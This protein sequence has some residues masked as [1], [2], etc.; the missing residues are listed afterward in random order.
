M[1]DSEVHNRQWE[2]SEKERRFSGPMAACPLSLGTACARTQASAPACAPL[3]VLGPSPRA[4]LATPT[5]PA[6]SLRI[7]SAL[8][9]PESRGAVGPSR[10]SLGSFSRAVEEKVRLWSSPVSQWVSFFS[11]LGIARCDPDSAQSLDGEKR[12]TWPAS[13]IRPFKDSR[14]GR[15][16][17]EIHIQSKSESQRHTGSIL[18]CVA[19]KFSRV[20]AAK[21]SVSDWTQTSHGP[22]TFFWQKKRKQKNFKKR[23]GFIPRPQQCSCSLKRSQAHWLSLGSFSIGAV[24]QDMRGPRA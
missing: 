11:A 1:R 21:R 4:G 18:P 23:D 22:E 8:A 5:P 9:V 7:W 6:A 20:G 2:E 24:D 10:T 12:G 17:G 16:V 15:G 13:R 19:G 3:T 14:N